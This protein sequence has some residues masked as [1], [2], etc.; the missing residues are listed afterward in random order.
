MFKK[1][2]WTALIVGGVLFVV[3]GSKFFGYVKDEVSSARNWLDDQVPVEK[4]LQRLNGEVDRLEKD[5]NKVKD[6]LAKELHA[7]EKQEK[8]VTLKEAKLDSQQKEMLVRHEQ[9]EQMA[10]DQFV[11]FGR[12]KLS[13]TDAV[14]RLS[15]DSKLWQIERDTLNRQQ[16]SVKLTMEN[17]AH[18][19]KQRA[20]LENQKGILKARLQKIA[21]DHKALQAKKVETQYK[22]DDTRLSKLLKDIEKLED[23]LGVQSKRVE[24]DRPTAVS[25]QEPVES[26][27]DIAARLR[28]E[29]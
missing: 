23:R 19:Q 10:G 21:N 16:E 18:L 20:E 4:E 2:F 28:G 7:L 26:L 5:I 13:K 29:K 9:I 15:A 11:T 6:N 14:K 1:L 24:M 27:E 22:G 12:E 17:V 3:K 25:Q 8:E